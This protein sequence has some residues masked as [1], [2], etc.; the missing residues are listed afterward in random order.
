MP[1]CGK[2]YAHP[3]DTKVNGGS[4]A[5]AMH[6]RLA[7]RSLTWFLQLRDKRRESVA[8]RSLEL[9]GMDPHH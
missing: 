8:L 5:R 3:L 1:K 9:L 2:T 7:G 6:L 4:M